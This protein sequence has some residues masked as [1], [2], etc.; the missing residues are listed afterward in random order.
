MALKPVDKVFGGYLGFITVLILVRGPFRDASNGWM[1]GMHVLF[2]ILLYLF[3]KLQEEDRIGQIIRNLYPLAMFLVLYAEIGLLN[4]Q[5]PAESV[6][7]NDDVIQRWEEFIFQSQISYTWLR[8]YPSVFWSGLLHL[9]YFG[10]YPIVVFG[11]LLVALRRSGRDVRAVL[12]GTSIAFVICYVTF[13]L[14]PVAGPNYAFDHPTGPVRE[15]W[16]ARLIYTLLES[17]S[18][19]GA[20]FPSSHVAATVATTLGLWRAW[21]ALGAWFTVPCILL[22]VGTVYCQMHYGIDA[23]TGIVVGVG[24]WLVARRLEA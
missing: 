24:A 7:A 10:Y 22:I 20:A 1:L 8:Q 17:G 3:T 19:F 21:R 18:S 11:P 12:L 5:F 2:G 13:V 9:A 14:Y 4:A 23:A 6:F 16:S 15:V